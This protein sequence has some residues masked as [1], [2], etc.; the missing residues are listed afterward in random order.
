MSRFAG[1]GAEPGVSRIRRPR[2]HAVDA[3]RSP[4]RPHPRTESAASPGPRG[5][6]ST[7]RPSR[8]SRPPGRRT[9]SGLVVVAGAAPPHQREGHRDAARAAVSIPSAPAST[10]LPRRVHR[11][12][13]P[14]SAP[15]LDGSEAGGWLVSRGRRPSGGP[16]S[17]RSPTGSGCGR[18]NSRDGRATTSPPSRSPT[19]SHASAG[20]CGATVGASSPGAQPPEKGAPHP[21]TDELQRDDRTTEHRSDRR[22][23]EPDNE[24]GSQEPC[25][26][27]APRARLSIVARAKAAHRR[28]RDTTAVDHPS[29]TSPLRSR[30]GVQIGP[31]M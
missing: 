18:P 19:S 14:H 28:A 4:N 25:S 22:G 8:R 16:R 20:A 26:R 12:W 9:R 15:I 23:V 21:T 30:G 3:A 2:Q 6:P 24:S 10:G 27:L 13:L 5:D 29:S 31:V 17:P 7:T 1:S 11:S